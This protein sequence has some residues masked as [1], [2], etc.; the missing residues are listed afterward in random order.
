MM[1]VISFHWVPFYFACV[2]VSL[3]LDNGL[4]RTPA[5]GYNTW[6]DFVGAIDESNCRETVDAFVD[7]KFPEF[8]YNY[9]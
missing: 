5:M 9:W 7:K 1:R 4:G 8:G 2:S 6:Y 3:A